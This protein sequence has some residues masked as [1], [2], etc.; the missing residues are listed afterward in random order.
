MPRTIDEVVEN[1]QLRHRNQIVEIDHP[2]AGKVSTA[3]VT[4]KLSDTPLEIRRPPPTLGQHT[5][6][7]LSDWLSLSSSRIKDLMDDAV[8]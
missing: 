1:A 4:M 7:V 5:V 3:G 8:V 6:D 2:V